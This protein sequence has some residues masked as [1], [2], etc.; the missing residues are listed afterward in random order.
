VI[1]ES[2]GVGRNW[3]SWDG[4]EQYIELYLLPEKW[5]AFEGRKYMRFAQAL[6]LRVFP[7]S[8]FCYLWHYS[9]PLRNES[10]LDLELKYLK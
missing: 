5:P 4:L 1:Y 7:F 8:R 2:K 3:W 10:V 9:V 6:S